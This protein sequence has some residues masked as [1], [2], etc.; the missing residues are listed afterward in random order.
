MPKDQSFHDY[1]IDDVLAGISGITSRAM[2]GGWGIYKNGVFFALIAEGEL[3]FKVDEKNQG[4]FEKLKSHPFV[5]L[6]AKKPMTMAYWLLPEEIMED[7]AKL[8]A[9]V[10]S[11]VAASKRSKTKKKK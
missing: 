6:G 2:F 3:Y 10:D 1:V 4:D 8:Q 7:K 9:W 11:S 5:Y